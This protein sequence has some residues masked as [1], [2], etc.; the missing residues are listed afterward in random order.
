MLCYG[1]LPKMQRRWRQCDYRL[2]IFKE[3]PHAAL[4]LATINFRG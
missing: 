2:S 3:K 4:A 1:G